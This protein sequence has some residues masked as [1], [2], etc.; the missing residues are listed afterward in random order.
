MAL[1]VRDPAQQES[2]TGG[3][4][5]GCAPAPADCVPV[6]TRWHD[7]A[8]VNAMTV[9]LED[10]A[11]STLGPETPLTSRVV[12]N[13]ERLLELLAEHKVRATFFA[14]GKVCERFPELLPMVAAA[15][16]EIGTHGYGHELV[17]TITPERFRSDLQRSIEIVGAQAG[18]APR[19]YR[20]PAF[21]IGPRSR[22]AGGILAELGIKY[23]S[24]VFPIR[25]RRY[26]MP[27]APRFPHRWSDCDLIEFPLTTVRRLGRNLPV[28]GGGY[29]RLLPSFLL[30]RA[31]RELNGQR[32]P[33]VVYMHPYELDVHELTELRR[34]GWRFSR[35][36]QLTQ[37]LFRGRM[38]GRLSAVFRE[39]AFAPM[40]EVLNLE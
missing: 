8:P 36:I 39:F 16:H 9:D 6:A 5:A 25:G 19:G 26:G 15:G 17:H 40:A 31:I 21:S 37:S 7:G 22:W 28:S 13:T 24:S 33:V 29:F 10:W 32:H 3:R 11:Q 18:R 1:D 35:R 20:A 38:R 27:D 14:L 23:S 12:R 30:A 4:G 2:D 34:E